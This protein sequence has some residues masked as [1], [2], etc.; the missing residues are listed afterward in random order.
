MTAPVV[1][2]VIPTFNR[3]GLLAEAIAS[4][5]DQDVEGLEVIVSDNASTDA[6]A[7]VVAGFRDPRLRCERLVENIGMAANQLRA[8]LLGTGRYLCIFQDDD[9]MLPGNLR[10]KVEL[11]EDHPDV[12]MVHSAFELRTLDGGLVDPCANWDLSPVDVIRTGSEFI[13]RTLV[14]GRRTHVSASLYRRDALDVETL[15]PL[16]GESIE[17]ALSLRAAHH[18]SVA[19]LATPLC[20]VRLHASQNSFKSGV[21][22]VV[23][24][25]MVRTFTQTEL[26]HQIS[27]AFLDRYPVSDR[28]E[29][30]AG[31]ARWVGHELRRQIIEQLPPR[32]AP[33]MAMRRL[34][35]AARIE[36]AAV[37]T[38]KA[39]WVVLNALVGANGRSQLRR[40]KKI[41]ERYRSGHGSG[42][43]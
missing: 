32:P 18:G 6:T 43:R 31:S 5:L 20:T 33:F 7:E 3:A 15:T 39:V 25:E 42:R 13:R 24:G 8:A 21:S 4:V 35:E 11:L 17:L 28:Q 27:R 14:M 38:P 23:G 41:F 2:V 34:R 10:R 30:A 19:F 26:Y 29:L 16:D 9:L 12:A 36:A 1:S 22:A 37:R 40:A